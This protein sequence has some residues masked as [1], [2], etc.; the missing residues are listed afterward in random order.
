MVAFGTLNELKSRGFSMD[1]IMK[2]Y[3]DTH[4]VL[5]ETLIDDVPSNVPGVVNSTH[6]SIEF[7][8]DSAASERVNVLYC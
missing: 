5:S 1:D 4:T 7:Y 8:N 3:G 6:D 2:M